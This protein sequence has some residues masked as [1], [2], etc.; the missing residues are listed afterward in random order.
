M[1]KQNRKKG[2]AKLINLFLMPVVKPFASWHAIQLAFSWSFQV[3][4]PLVEFSL[5][6]HRVVLRALFQ[7]EIH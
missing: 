3:R 2:I 6:R 1:E 7:P 5:E 4:N